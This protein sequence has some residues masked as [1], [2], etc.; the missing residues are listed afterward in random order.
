[1]GSCLSLHK[2]QNL[3]LE[4]EPE[5]AGAGHSPIS[6]LSDGILY[7]VLIHVA[8]AEPIYDILGFASAQSMNSTYYSCLGWTRLSAVCRRW[9]AIV[10]DAASLW[11]E[12]VFGF[13]ADMA[14]LALIRSGTAP[15]NMIIPSYKSR[16]PELLRQVQSKKKW[17]LPG[18]HR[19][20][21]LNLA[22][23]HSDRIKKLIASD[24]SSQHYHMIFK[25]GHFDSLTS[26]SLEYAYKNSGPSAPSREDLDD[27]CIV[28]P[29]V[30]V[31]GF[32]P[33]L[34]IAYDDK[35]GLHI[36]LP[37]LRKLIIVAHVDFRYPTTL[38]TSMEQLCWIPSLICGAPMLEHLAIDM[39][40]D[41]FVVDW[42]QLFSGKRS[43]LPA[44]RFCDVFGMPETHLEQLF[45]LIAPDIPPKTIIRVLLSEET[46]AQENTELPKTI[47][48]YGSIIGHSIR[49]HSLDTV[50]LSLKLSSAT[51]K[52]SPGDKISAATFLLSVFRGTELPLL[53]CS[54]KDYNNRCSS[55]TA[56]ADLLA[57][58]A[59]SQPERNV[60][61]SDVS[62]AILKMI[63]P[64]L[65]NNEI[66]TLILDE[67]PTVKWAN[68]MREVMRT[69]L[70]SV[71]TL[72]CVNTS[73]C[74]Y[75]KNSV[76]SYP[77]C[78]TALRLLYDT[79]KKEVRG[80]SPAGLSESSH[81]ADLPHTQ[82]ALLF[83]TSGGVILPALETVVVSMN[84]A[85]VAEGCSALR[86]TADVRAWWDE[87]I[88]AL[89]R[90]HDLGLRVR[91]LRIVGGWPTERLRK[92]TA[93]MDA[94]MLA[95]AG[96]L[97]DDVAD[98]RTVSSQLG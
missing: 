34:P 67:I 12:D 58:S 87:L 30:R 7:L 72:Y 26:L 44:L 88:R 61:P 62:D 5:Q 22:V 84:V 81:P 16:G 69:F 4:I 76:S 6:L 68:T 53:K 31:A 45:E 37:A 40:I 15:L 49:L 97:V 55:Q 73:D 82:K 52:W 83:G 25:N 48:T 36:V 32:S 23:T 43:S 90:R 92:R 77:P 41:T 19:E 17:G 9:R 86:S 20:R 93:K 2:P 39:P 18:T 3:D 66:R 42:V 78:T 85:P 51:F 79:N 57:V 75:A 38:P 94:K 60:D 74:P 10:I 8:G 71:T 54:M 96:V 80:Q 11:A 59:S 70:P 65:I 1:M 56:R 24:L 47:E 21:L 46:S 33:T 63:A 98:E 13:P 27:L 35:P 64:I 89:T 29:H 91:V 28:A 95:R 50:H 14:A